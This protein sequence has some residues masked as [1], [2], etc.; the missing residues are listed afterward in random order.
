MTRMDSERA[1]VVAMNLSEQTVMAIVLGGT[2]TPPTP[3]PAIVPRATAVLGFMGFT[4]ASAPLK[5]AGNYSVLRPIED[6][7][8]LTH[9]NAGG[10][11]QLAIVILEN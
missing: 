9:D 11:H 5:A 7:L 1:T 3:K 6:R 10:N 4:T 2:K 8:E